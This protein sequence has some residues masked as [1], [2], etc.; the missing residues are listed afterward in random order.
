MIYEQGS[1]IPNKAAR[2]VTA[3]TPLFALEF[4]ELDRGGRLLEATVVLMDLFVGGQ[5]LDDS[6]RD[7]VLQVEVVR[8]V[9]RVG[10]SGLVERGRKVG[11]I[12]PIRLWV[13]SR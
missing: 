3:P 8:A 2:C 11:V 6:D 1:Q 9:A 10:M 4:A 7:G 5:H 13:L 12:L